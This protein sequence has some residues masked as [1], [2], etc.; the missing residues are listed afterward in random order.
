[1]ASG[2]TSWPARATYI[3]AL[4]R[5]LGDALGV[6]GHLTALRRTRSGGFGEDDAVA[7]DAVDASRLIPLGALLPAWP[8]V[9]VTERGVDAVR[10]GRAVTGTLAL[11]AWPSEAPHVRVLD[12]S[13]RLLAMAVARG[14]SADGSALPF[15]PSL[16]PEIVFDC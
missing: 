15:P 8:S 10:H 11:D 16:H 3:R 9:R 4:A 12:E 14:G 1:V 2:S 7:L 6:G 5:D 13:G